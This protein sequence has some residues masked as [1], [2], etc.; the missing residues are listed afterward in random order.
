MREM[1]LVGHKPLARNGK[2]VQVL[3]KGPFQQIIDDFGKVYVRGERVLIDAASE[4]RLHQSPM[5]DQFVFFSHEP[6][7]VL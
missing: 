1:Q 6:T 2:A 7:S 4:E 3:Y 5:A